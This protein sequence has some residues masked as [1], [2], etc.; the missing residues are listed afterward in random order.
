MRF[1]VERRVIDI[2]A[3]LKESMTIPLAVKL[4]PFYSSLPHLAAEVDRIG[5]DGL[6]L[7]NRFYEPDID[8]ER[9]APTWRLT[10]SDSRELGLRLQWIAMLAGRVRASL[11]VSGGVH[12]PLDAVKAILAGASAVQIVTALMTHGPAR[13]RQL[14]HEVVHR[15]LLEVRLREAREGE[16]LLGERVERVDLVADGGH[17]AA[18]VVHVHARAR[19]HDVLEHLGVQL[20]GADRVAHLVRHLQAEPPDGGHPLG[21]QQL[22]LR[23]LQ[24]AH[25][26]RQLGVEPAHLA[27]GPAL[28]LGHDAHGDPREPDEHG[29]DEDRRP[30]D[31]GRRQRG[32]RRV[33]ATGDQRGAQRDPGAEVVRVD[34]DQGEEQQVEDAL[35][36]SGQ[37]QEHEDEQEQRDAVAAAARRLQEVELQGR[38]G[39]DPHI[40][41]V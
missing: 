30:A 3:V 12:E 33:Q 37:G 23:R 9:L 26:A 40:A 10:P 19:A 25:R 7:F 24:P 8:P 18:G 34:G 36:A 1:F 38:Q 2:V 29:H 20:D 16:V 6:V 32:R 39:H 35:P 31:P 13:L 11:A 28:A 21:L 5:A 14:V 22:P 15:L 41:S 4:S 27:A 17:Q